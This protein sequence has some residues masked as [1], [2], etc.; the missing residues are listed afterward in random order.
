M[1]IT[2]VK[3]SRKVKDMIQ[4]YIDGDYS[5]SITEE[6]Y[7]R[8]NL[9]ERKELTQAEINYIKNEVNLNSAKSV[10]IRYLAL[11]LRTASEVYSKLESKEYDREIIDCVIEELKTMG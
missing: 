3:Q 9:Y 7:L 11:Q 5:F 10:A 6:D 4:I 1:L 8:L 2:S